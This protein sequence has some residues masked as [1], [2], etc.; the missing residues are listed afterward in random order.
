MTERE[1]GGAGE[2]GNRPEIEPLVSESGRLGNPTRLVPRQ[3]PD[4]E[5]MS[6]TPRPAMFEDELEP[7]A[8]PPAFG[9]PGLGPM[10]G[11]RTFGNGRVQVWGCSPG[12]LIASLIASLL[13]TILLNALF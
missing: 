11:P 10:F 8:P 5:P 13:L 1:I 4:D 9:R 6:V 7:Q 3:P 12:C 2:D